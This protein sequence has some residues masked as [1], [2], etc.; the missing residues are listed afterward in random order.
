MLMR[1][2]SLIFGGGRATLAD[3]AAAQMD[4]RSENAARMV[5]L[6]RPLLTR[7]LAPP[8]AAAPAGTTDAAPAAAATAP[9]AALA[10]NGTEVAAAQM[11]MEW[12][13]NLGP[14]S[15]PGAI[16]EVFR[17]KV[18]QC[19]ATIPSFS[20]SAPNAGLMQVFRQKVTQRLLAALHMPTQ[21][22]IEYVG[23]FCE[24]LY[25]GLNSLNSHD[26]DAVM[27]LLAADEASWQAG[28]AEAVLM[29]R[30]GGRCALVHTALAEACAELAKQYGPAPT[31]WK[32][33][34]LHNMCINHAFSIQKA[35]GPLFSA[36][37]FPCGGDI[38]TPCATAFN[39][40][41]PY[42]SSQGAVFRFVAQPSDWTKCRSFSDWREGRLKPV[43]W[44]RATIAQNTIAKMTFASS[45]LLEAPRPP[46][47]GSYPGAEKE[48]HTRG[49]DDDDEQAP[50]ATAAQAVPV[51]SSAGATA[52]PA[53]HQPAAAAA[54]QEPAPAAV[55]EPASAPAASAPAN[56]APAAAAVAAMTQ[57]PAAAAPVEPAAAQEPAA[58]AAAAVAAAQQPASRPAD[59]QP[60]PVA[61][62]VPKVEAA[63]PAPEVPS[64]PVDAA[65][66]TTGHDD[67]EPMVAA[68]SA[69]VAPAGIATAAPEMPS[70]AGTDATSN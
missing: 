9:P 35:L 19:L 36:P 67:D 21:H 15:A 68:P 61:A 37:A 48:C 12:D 26:V 13:G 5:A 8:Q 52:G 42:H 28:S 63:V 24:P 57:A 62:A 31:Q 25:K 16:Y 20:A 54:A 70:A 47:R 32:W 53:V 40:R 46:A 11:L 50:A 43:L 18:T 44:D 30:L 7:M 1:P 56:Q 17:Q 65:V 51:A 49:E 58:T 64:A 10:L 4:V 45:V 6:L 41:H 29:A 39:V 3:M 55:Q 27:R 33:G 2:S 59:A 66:P 34:T 22:A 38:D 14:D 23:A 69:G 60:V